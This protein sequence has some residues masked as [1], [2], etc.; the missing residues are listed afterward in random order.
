MKYQNM[1]HIP[2]LIQRKF[3]LS[4][5]KEL[6]SYRLSAYVRIA[7]EDFVFDKFESI[8]KDVLIYVK[9]W[10]QHLQ[11]YIWIYIFKTD[12]S[13]IMDSCK[14]KIKSIIERH[15]IFRNHLSL[16]ENDKFF[17]DKGDMKIFLTHF[18]ELNNFDWF[19]E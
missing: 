7:F 18:V 13:I 19:L 3:G 5:W 8:I 12:N 2:K 16:K 9:I 6:H 15:K 1:N 17:S 10:N 11:I 14:S 4:R